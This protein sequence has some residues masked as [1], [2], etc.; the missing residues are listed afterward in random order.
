MRTV[1]H[2]VADKHMRCQPAAPLEMVGH[3][4]PFLNP[5]RCSPATT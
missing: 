1:E 5:A 2:S 4:Q 3:N